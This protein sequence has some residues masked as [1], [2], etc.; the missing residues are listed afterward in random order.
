[1][2]TLKE[3]NF[4]GTES[5]LI[6]IFDISNQLVEK[7]ETDPQKRI[8]ELEWKKVELEVEIQQV[9]NGKIKILAKIK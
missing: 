8:A 5:R 2:T 4:I 6:T 1:M 9:K 7:T 3:N